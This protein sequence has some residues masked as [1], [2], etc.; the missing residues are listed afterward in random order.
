MAT[1]AG[2]TMVPYES[3]VTATHLKIR[4]R[5]HP[6]IPFRLTSARRCSHHGPLA[7]YVKLRVA[8]ALGMPGTFSS[9]PWVNDPD[10]HHG[11]CVTHVPWCMPRSLTSGFL[12]SR[13]RNPQFCVTGKRSMSDYL[14]VTWVLLYIQH[15]FNISKT[16]GS[17]PCRWYNYHFHMYHPI[18]H[19]HSISKLP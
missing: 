4:P 10:M 9:P 16:L 15:R 7:R 18:D 6:V 1:I 13:M 17:L 8:H 12:W 11:T 5:R 2:D 3:L 19:T 14:A